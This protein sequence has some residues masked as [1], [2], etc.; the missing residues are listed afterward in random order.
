MTVDPTLQLDLL[1]KV[2]AVD[3][4]GGSRN[5]FQ[6]GAAR[7]AKGRNRP[8]DRAE[9]GGG[10]FVGPEAPPPPPAPPP[11]QPEPPPPPIPLKYYAYWIARDNGQ[12]DG[13]LPGRRGDL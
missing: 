11:P 3:L 8:K 7:S 6:F 10:P 5:L 13:V 1:A 9:G 2:Q 12:E 4:A